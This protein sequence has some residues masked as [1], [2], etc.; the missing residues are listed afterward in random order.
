MFGKK[1]LKGIV[2][3]TALAISAASVAHAGVSCPSADDVKKADRALNTVIRQ[4]QRAFFVLSAQ[5]SINSSGMGWIVATQASGSGFDDAFNK[6]QESVRSV[7]A[8]AMDTPIEQQG[9]LI[10]PYLTTSGGM[11]VMA[12]APQQQGLVFNPTMLN[13]DKIKLKN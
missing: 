3:V 6:G 9:V 12:V 5:P 8:A 13:M 2:A 4:S 1:S 11:N 7:I 10:C